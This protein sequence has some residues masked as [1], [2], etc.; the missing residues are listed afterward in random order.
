MADSAVAVTEGSGKNI[1]TRTEVTNGNHRQVVVVGDPSTNAGVAPVDGTAGLKVDLGTDNDV[2]LAVLPD[3]ASG[4][5]AAIAA[6]V[7]GTLTVGSHEVTN[8]GTFAVQAA[9]SGTWTVQPGNTAN[10]TAWLVTGTGGTFPATQSGTW[11]IGTVTAVTGITNALPAGTNAI[12]KLAANSGVDIGDVDVTSLTGII[13]PN[14]EYET[15]AASQTAQVLGA[16]GGTG[17]YLDHLVVV[18]ASTSPGNVIILDNATSITVFAG[19]TDSVLTLHPFTIDI[20]AYSTSGA[21][22]VTTGGNV[23]VFAVG[24]FS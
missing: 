4:D 5:L 18:P 22:K 23:S 24:N 3:T 17:D 6:A 16:T 8:A 13:A 20:R 21:W 7:G 2:T 9:Q 1:D 12:G 14:G 10:T 11:N 15:V 19:G